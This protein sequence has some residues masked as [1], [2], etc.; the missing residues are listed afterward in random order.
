MQR[1]VLGAVCALVVG[2]YACAAHTVVSELSSPDA[3]DAYYNLLVQGFCAGQLSLKKEVPPG[4]GRLADPYDP[5]ANAPYRSAPYQTTDLS[6][7]KGRFYLYFGVTPAL[8]LF[9][10]FV[11]LTGHYLSPKQAVVIFFAIGFLASVGLLRALWRRYFAEVGVGVVAACA[12]ALGL[13]TG[14]PVL[15]QRGA[16]HEV[17]ISCGYMLTMLALGALWGALHEPERRCRWLAAASAAYGLALGARPSLLLGAVILLVPVVQTWGER[18]QIGSLLMAATGPIL[19]IGLGLMLYNYLRFDNPLEFGLRYQLNWNRQDMVQCFSL[20]YLWFNFRVYFLEPARWGGRF[21]FVHEIVVPP[22]P[23]GYSQ[24]EIPFGVLSN[25]PLVWLALAAPLAWRGRSAEARC[26]LRGFLA[27]V[28]LLSGICALT[29]GLFFGACFRYEVDFLPTLVLLAVVGILGLEHVLAPTSESGLADRPVWRGA[30]RC[31]WGLI[32]GF[33]VAFNLFVT[34]E[35]Y[36]EEC[37]SIGV[38]L[39]HAGRVQE[40]IGQFEQALRIKPDYADAHNNLGSALWQA[41]RIQEAI[42][43]YEQALRIKPDHAEAHNNLGIALEQE[44]RV[45]E[46]IGQYEQALRIKPGYAE[47]HYNLGNALLRLGKASEAI[48]YYEQALRIK[49][50]FAEA[51]GNL[52]SALWQASRIQEA[53]KHYEQALRVKPDYA[54]AHYNLGVALEQTGRVQEAIEHYEQ[55]LRFKPDFAEAHYNLGNVLLRLGKVSEAIAYYEQALRIKPDHADAHYNLALALEQAGNLKDAIGHFE[56]AVRIKPDMAEGHNNLGLALLQLG[57]VPGAIKQ[58]ER[59]LQ[60]KPDDAKAHYNLGLA[61]AGQDRLA[62][63]TAEYTAALRSKPDDAKAHYNLAIVLE[64][65]GRVQEAIEHYEQ[66]LRIKSDFTE[67][68]AKL[69][70]ARQALTKLQEHGASGQR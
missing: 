65:E 12:L 19:V 43:H 57:R 32:L 42:K 17:A 4:L 1:G 67:A 56:Q 38:G 55:A 61:L 28:A 49:P 62:E 27:A 31:G 46:A 9:W 7:Y 10:P 18:R 51:H 48:A 59:A 13:A 63:A 30:V 35:R 37:I 58:F 44:G 11:A 69:Q 45:Q 41:S 24:V 47:S 8:I 36:A 16:P 40:A 6:Y 60:I 54:D 5:V 64:Q 50:D 70:L 25:V 15:L 53:I 3:A 68:R 14:V 26:I 29:I 21:P 22:L 34:A 39:E 52:G 20:R 33:S 66:A 23:A 2:V